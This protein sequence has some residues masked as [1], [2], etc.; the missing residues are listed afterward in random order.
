MGNFFGIFTANLTISCC[1]GVE[2]FRFDFRD[3]FCFNSE[4]SLSDR[5]RCRQ[6][7]FDFFDMIAT[8]DL[9]IM[10]IS[11]LSNKRFAGS[12]LHEPGGVLVDAEIAVKLHA[13]NAFK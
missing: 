7:D 12:L 11:A 9:G 8:C 3:L 10:S 2:I 13:R 4:M 6:S 5:E 1:F